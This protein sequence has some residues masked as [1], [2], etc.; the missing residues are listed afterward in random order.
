MLRATSVLVSPI[1]F[2]EIGQQVRFG[3]WPGMAPFV[4]RLPELLEEQ[5]GAVVDL[6]PHICRRAATMGWTH[7]DP[8]DRMLA[9]TAER[10]HLP[11]ISADTIFDGL[12]TR[13]W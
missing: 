2:Y 8:F 1:S 6:D 3:K 5:G 4:D 10:H 11:L 13:V 12:V 9:A 7:R